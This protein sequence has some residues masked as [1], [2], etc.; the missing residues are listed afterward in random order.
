MERDS[1]FME[2]AVF[3]MRV[4]EGQDGKH[5]A[6]SLGISEPTVSRRLAAVRRRLRARLFEVFSRYS[7]TSD[8][9]AELERNG[10]DLDPNKQREASLDQAIADIYHRNCA[11]QAREAAD[12]H[13]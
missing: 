6:A 12:A 10:I 9:M 5:T 1:E 7:F 11:R 4:L 3:R 2:F 8:E 13:P